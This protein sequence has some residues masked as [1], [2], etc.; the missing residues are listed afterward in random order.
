MSEFNINVPQSGMK[1]RKSIIDT[2]KDFLIECF[3][4]FLT[5]SEIAEKIGV[6]R[7][8]IER[9]YKTLNMKRK[10]VHKGMLK[11]KYSYDRNYFE[12][13]DTEDKA[14][15]LGF[16]YADGCNT[17]QGFRLQISQKDEDVLL[18][19]KE[20]IKYTGKL[21][22]KKGGEMKGL[23]NN[24]DKIYITNPTCVFQLKS[25]HVSRQLI[26]LGCIPKKSLILKFPT[27][28]Q[29]PSYLLHHFMRGYFDGDGCV[30]IYNTK[31]RG[32]NETKY[33]VCIAGTENFIIDLQKILIKECRL[34]KTKIRN[35]TIST[36]SYG[37]R[38]QIL[39]IKEYLYKNATIYMD[40]KFK[41]F[42]LI[43]L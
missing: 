18:K 20:N 40:R 41:K 28:E 11:T 34:N 1:K 15:F 26:K 21:Y 25:T 35:K 42:N 37:S 14:Y 27:E 39:R 17:K 6:G 3:N 38:L 22:Y 24:K 10:R 8:T 31:Q 12:K 5:Y 36:L 7:R 29:V 23:G 30:S 32:W 33:S 19:L 16:L 4:K 43:P 13:I 9:A 2:H